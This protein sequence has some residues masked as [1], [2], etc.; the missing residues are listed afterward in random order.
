MAIALSTDHRVRE[1]ASSSHTTRIGKTSSSSTSFLTATRRKGS[2]PATRPA[3]PVS[4]PASSMSGEREDHAPVAHW[5]RQPSAGDSADE[6]RNDGLDAEDA[7]AE[8]D[9]GEAAA[10]EGVDFLIDEAALGTDGYRHCVARRKWTGHNCL[11]VR[12]KAA[13]S[14]GDSVELIL[15]KAAE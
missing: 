3:G 11:R 6:I 14:C 7:G 9:R 8:V 2:G 5:R 12:D 1:R 4:S 15:H 10:N 13:G